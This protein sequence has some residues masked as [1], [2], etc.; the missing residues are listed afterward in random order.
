[1]KMKVKAVTAE[2]RASAWILGCMPFVMFGIIMMIN[3]EY[4][5][6][7]LTDPRGITM[8]LVG[9]TMTSVGIAIMTRMAKFEI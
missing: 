6:V 1:M 8:M 3:R 9:L 5:M 2:A 4:A 7:L